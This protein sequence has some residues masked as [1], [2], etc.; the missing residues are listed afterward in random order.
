MIKVLF[1][2]SIVLG[3]MAVACGS[4]TNKDKTP[5]ASPSKGNT[6]TS[7]S[8]GAS[9]QTGSGDSKKTEESDQK[10]E[11]LK[12]TI[13]LKGYH[14]IAKTKAINVGAC[15]GFQKKPPNGQFPGIAKGPCPDSLKV[16]SKNAESKMMVA[17]PADKSGEPYFQPFLYENVVPQEGNQQA[18]K[19]LK[20]YLSLKT[21]DS[22]KTI[23]KKYESKAPK[24]K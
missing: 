1:L 11:E 19:P 5:A 2:L 18:S 20:D 7:T 9:G 21:D 10:K 15:L 3:A 14:W 16:G 13:E 4:S 6:Q 24:G 23:C 17:C 22:A 8:Q 12:G